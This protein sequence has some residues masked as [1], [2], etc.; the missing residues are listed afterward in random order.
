VNSYSG[1]LLPAM[2]GHPR[3]FPVHPPQAMPNYSRNFPAQPHHVIFSF[4]R[5]VLAQPPQAIPSYSR[6]CSGPARARYSQLFPAKP[7]PSPRTLFPAISGA[8]PASSS[9]LFPAIPPVPQAIP[10]YSRV[11]QA[12][13]GPGP[14]R[15]VATWSNPISRW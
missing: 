1:T 4:P 2:P 9:Q 8:A 6:Q 5:L 14:P 12:I 13:P 3:L 15:G 7:G 10:G 11:L